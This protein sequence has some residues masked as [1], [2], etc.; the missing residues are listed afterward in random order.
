MTKEL[1]T[2]EELVEIFGEMMPIAG[3]QLLCDNPDRLSVDELR[4]ALKAMA[5]ERKS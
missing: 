2:R 3:A 4:V 5:A 1:I